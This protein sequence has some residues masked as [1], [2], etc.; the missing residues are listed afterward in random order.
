[1]FTRPSPL[2][3]RSDVITAAAQEFGSENGHF[4]MKI[5]DLYGQQA[6]EPHREWMQIVIVHYAKDDVEKLLTFVES[7]KRDYEKFL[8]DMAFAAVP[9]ELEHW[10]LTPRPHLPPIGV[11]TKEGAANLL[12]V[13]WQQIDEWV[14]S[15]VLRPISKLRGKYRFAI[16]ELER[17]QLACDQSDIDE[18]WTE[19]REP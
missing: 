1:M 8:W 16:E 18:I 4:I 11:W 13:D 19:I 9:P 7:A 3:T 6:N 2:P 10:D 17:F 15:G 14:A 12:G 5:L